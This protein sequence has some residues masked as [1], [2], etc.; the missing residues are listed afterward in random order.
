V[1]EQFA[2]DLIE[3]FECLQ[4][5]ALPGLMLKRFQSN[6]GAQEL[7]GIGQAGELVERGFD[8][9][10]SIG[11]LDASWWTESMR[12]KPGRCPGV[13]ARRMPMAGALRPAWVLT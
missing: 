2:F 10:M 3:V 11:A 9:M 6:V 4:V 1:F 8:V 7:F 13:G 12:M 5:I